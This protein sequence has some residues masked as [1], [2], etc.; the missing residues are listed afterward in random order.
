[1][2][3]QVETQLMARLPKCRLQPFTPPFM[4][5]S[6][7]YFGPFEVKIG[8]NKTA[9]HYGELFTC[10]NTRVGHCE[11]ATDASTTE[12]LQVLRSFFSY[13]G[14]PEVLISDNGSQMV[15]ADREL[16][17]MIE[18]WDIAKLKEFAPTEV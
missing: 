2:E 10:L 15:G 16:Q 1:M 8:R 11:L 6:C 14:Y 12:F 5:T 3:A 13:R 4:Y 7:D 17:L 9:K 18:G